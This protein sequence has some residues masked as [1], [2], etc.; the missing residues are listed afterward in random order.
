MSAVLDLSLNQQ[1]A[2]FQHSGSKHMDSDNLH[3]MLCTKNVTVANLAS[4]VHSLSKLL[5]LYMMVL[6]QSSRWYRQSCV[7]SYEAFL[8]KASSWM[9][10]LSSK[11]ERMGGSEL[12]TQDLRVVSRRE[13]L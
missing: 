2:L 1:D 6:H 3:L 13:C 7:T 11:M 12:T 5:L 4:V 9:T 10:G 8:S